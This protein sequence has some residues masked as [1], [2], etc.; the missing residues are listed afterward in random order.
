MATVIVFVIVL[1][2]NMPVYYS[3]ITSIDSIFDA[4]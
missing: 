4:Q 2:I 1:T 3:G